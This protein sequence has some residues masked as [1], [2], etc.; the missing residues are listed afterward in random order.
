MPKPSAL[1]IDEFLGDKIDYRARE[2]A[3]DEN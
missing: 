1:A 2:E 3:T